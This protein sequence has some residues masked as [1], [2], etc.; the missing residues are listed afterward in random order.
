MHSHI[1][2]IENVI[3]FVFNFG[4]Y[5]CSFASPSINLV[6]EI[7]LSLDVGLLLFV[8]RSDGSFVD[9]VSLQHGQPLQS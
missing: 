8:L 7:E 4:C 9:L 2:T 6:D 1:V 5:N 3:E